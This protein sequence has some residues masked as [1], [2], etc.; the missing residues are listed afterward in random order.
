MYIIFVSWGDFLYSPI[1]LIK[2]RLTV[3]KFVDHCCS[4]MFVLNVPC[5]FFYLHRRNSPCAQGVLSRPF[6]SGLTMIWL[7]ACVII[8]ICLTGKS[9]SYQSALW[10]IALSYGKRRFSSSCEIVAYQL[11]ELFHVFSHALRI[12]HFNVYHL[13]R[14]VFCIGIHNGRIHFGF[15]IIC[16]YFCNVIYQSAFAHSNVPEAN[17]FLFSCP[18][19]ELC[20]ARF[21]WYSL[22]GEAS[23]QI[24]YH[25]WDGHAYS[26]KCVLFW[27]N[28][29]LCYQQNK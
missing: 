11:P 4:L 10:T 3:A 21:A 7:V 24:H 27:S 20:W 15:S 17:V 18:R 26:N 1:W 2:C 8:V 13:F 25:I 22:H 19:M 6:L 16:A 12:A 29:C 28:F 9:L 14:F 5:I 23:G